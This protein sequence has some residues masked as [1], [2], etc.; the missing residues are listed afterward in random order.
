MQ[1]K[2]TE[3]IEHDIVYSSLMNPFANVGNC[4]NKLLPVA[5]V[6]PVGNES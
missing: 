4:I 2:F 5:R 6:N 1:Y 3:A